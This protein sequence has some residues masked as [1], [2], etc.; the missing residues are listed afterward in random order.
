MWRYFLFLKILILSSFFKLILFLISI[1]SKLILLCEEID[2]KYW[3]N[4]NSLFQNRSR[5]VSW[6]KLAAKSEA[7]I[8]AM[9]ASAFHFKVI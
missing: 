5:I 9:S 7:I 4:L 6:G 1:F 3:I 8:A 2:G